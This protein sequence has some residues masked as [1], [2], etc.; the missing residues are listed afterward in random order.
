MSQPQEGKR[1]VPSTVIK[2]TNL[3]EIAENRSTKKVRLREEDPPD[4]GTEDFPMVDLGPSYKDMLAGGEPRGMEDD[5]CFDE[6]E[7]AYEEGDIKVVEGENGPEV[8]LTESFVSRLQKP[9][10]RAA[11]LKVMGRNVG[12]QTFKTKL[13]L[14]WKPTGP[15]QI[16]DLENN[17]FVARFVNSIDYENVLLNGPWSVYGHAVYVQPWSDDFRPTKDT[18]KNVAVWIRF[19][20]YP[21]GRYHS[22]ILRT[23]RDLVGRTVKIDSNTAK[24]KR[25]KFAK[26]AVAIDV[27]KPLKDTVTLQG[28][29]IK[30]CYEG[31]PPEAPSHPPKKIGEWVNVPIRA[32]RPPRRNPEPQ[33]LHPTSRGGTSDNRYAALAD[34][35][36]SNPFLPT[37]S[38]YQA[39]PSPSPPLSFN[40]LN[41]KS[42]P[43]HI[44]KKGP[45]SRKT[46]DPKKNASSPTPQKSNSPQAQSTRTPLK[47]I[48]NSFEHVPR[49]SPLESKFL[50]PIPSKASSSKMHNTHT[51]INLEESQHATI[52]TLTPQ[53]TI[54][55]RKPAIPEQQFYTQ[56][57]RKQSTTLPLSSPDPGDLIPPV[58]NP[59]PP[60]PNQPLLRS[61]L[62]DTTNDPGGT[63]F[64]MDCE[65]ENSKG[66]DDVDMDISEEMSTESAIPSPL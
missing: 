57:T 54:G 16:I 28:E 64:P 48:S 17:Y 53:P 23:L 30:V 62:G 45:I 2:S 7:P 34:S 9:W 37:P 3:A 59:N 14:Q 39:R 11:I 26:V 6:D 21:L 1:A 65:G 50:T 43:K 33:V 8:Q 27:T 35:D 58:T 5:A 56:P 4:P 51:V 32:R 24:S 61:N 31:L 25:G 55:Y 66:N 63:N 52:V 20:D 46:Q 49:P 18:I 60:A 22:R 38:A 15:Y 10:Q 13:Q 40:T 44:N 12:Y 19:P 36:I 42:Q 29:T 47:D 41:F